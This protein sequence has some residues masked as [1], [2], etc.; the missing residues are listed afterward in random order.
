MACWNGLNALAKGMPADGAA[1][2]GENW[3][4]LVMEATRGMPYNPTTE[5]DLA[6]WEIARSVRADPE[7]YRVVSGLTPAELAIRYRS[8]S[9]PRSLQEP[10]AA[11]LSRYGMRGLG[12]IDMGR[13]RW[14]ENPSH[15]FEMLASFL[16]IEDED[17]APDAVFGRGAASAERAIEEIAAGV[18]PTRMGWF[19]SRAVRFLGGR[20]R[21]LMGMRESPKFFAV[22]MLGQIQHEILACGQEFVRSGELE[23]ADDLF[24]LTIDEIQAFASG[25]LSEPGKLIQTR[26]E[27][28]RREALRK[29]IPRLLLSDGRAF[30]EGINQGANGKNGLNGSP[31]SPG[32]AEGRVRVVL[33]PSQA[34]LQPGEILVCPGTDPSW[35]P[36]FL[37]AGGLVMEVGGMMTHGA[38]VAR[39]YGIPAI[40][41]VDQATTR[42]QTGQLI[43][44]DG[45]S[46]LIVRLDEGD[47]AVEAA[48]E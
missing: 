41:G 6:L 1:Q 37:S 39:E 22:R 36:L 15:V 38:V 25:E 4:R 23:R 40:V 47:G 35:T 10:V 32:I 19:K 24:Y 44:M 7:L 9:L 27:A 43:R 31:V 33:D 13:E 28:S 3:G 17:Q 11:F 26:R 16:Q 5:M 20:A 42:L 46:G 2:K 48:N 12:E 30:Y 29:Q 45:S 34:H 18:R 14:A 21:R 8:Q